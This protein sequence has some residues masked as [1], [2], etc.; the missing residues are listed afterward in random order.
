MVRPV[1]SRLF[2]GADVRE[3]LVLVASDLLE[4]FYTKIR[5]GLYHGGMTGKGVFLSG[6]PTAAVSFDCGSR[7]LVINP[8]L[9]VPNL[10]RHFR[11]YI[12]K[13]GDPSS[14]RLREKFEQCFD[15]K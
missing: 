9:L 14:V 5:C 6:D 2:V 10:V 4:S 8:H 3:P 11:S 15:G 13:L 12:N 1:S 7:T